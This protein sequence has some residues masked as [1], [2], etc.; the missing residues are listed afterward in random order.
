MTL[1][2]TDASEDGSVG[3]AGTPLS[4]RPFPPGQPRSNRGSP[5]PEPP[6]GHDARA[7]PAPSVLPLDPPFFPEMVLMPFF[8]L[9]TEHRRMEG[10]WLYAD[11]NV[12]CTWH[13]DQCGVFSIRC[14]S[15]G[16][17]HL[18]YPCFQ[19]MSGE[20]RRTCPYC[21]TNPLEVDIFRPLY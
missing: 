3:S 1:D 11:N 16:L 7:S 6:I 12:R 20:A 9:S 8:Y 13:H 14:G 18:C 19:F 15:C 17:M 10:A 4:Q 21:N 2:D 5:Q